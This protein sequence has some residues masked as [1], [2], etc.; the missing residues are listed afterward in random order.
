[1]WKYDDDKDYEFDHRLLNQRRL[2]KMRT[3]HE[4]VTKHNVDSVLRESD[5]TW[6][7]RLAMYHAQSIMRFFILETSELI[8][9]GGRPIIDS[10]LSCLPPCLDANHQLSLSC[11]ETFKPAFLERS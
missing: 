9:I 11:F 6:V 5:F 2:W 10:A 1:M 4:I 7:S 8:V 3:L